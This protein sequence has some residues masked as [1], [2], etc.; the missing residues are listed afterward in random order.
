M[1]ALGLAHI[2]DDAI[3]VGMRQLTHCPKLTQAKVIEN[4][5]FESSRQEA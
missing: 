1:N 3:V 5:I 2:R 4:Q